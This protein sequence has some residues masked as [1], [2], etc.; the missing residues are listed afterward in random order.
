LAHRRP[1][2]PIGGYFPIVAQV[3]YRL[4]IPKA[5]LSHT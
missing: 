4:V 5:I 2:A 1:S 3:G